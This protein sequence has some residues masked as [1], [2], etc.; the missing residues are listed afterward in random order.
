MAIHP[1]NTRQTVTLPTALLDRLK[2]QQGDGQTL[3]DVIRQQLEHGYEGVE[4]QVM[5]VHE[6]LNLIRQ[7]LFRLYALLEQVVKT[8]EEMM[9]TPA[10]EPSEPEPDLPIVTYEE[11]YADDPLY[12]PP[13]PPTRT[14][15]AFPT[16]RPPQER[17]RWWHR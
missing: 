6:G 5:D 2:A 9:P 11:M 17:K 4:K 12:N 8:L 16:P 14:D 10:P 1:E 13:I 3:S 15:E 7:D